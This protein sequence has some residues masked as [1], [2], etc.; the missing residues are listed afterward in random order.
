MQRRSQYSSP[1]FKAISDRNKRPQRYRQT[2]SPPP[3]PHPS[4][5]RNQSHAAKPNHAQRNQAPH[6]R[7]SQTS[8][9]RRELQKIWRSVMGIDRHEWEH[10]A[11]KPGGRMARITRESDDPVPLSP[12]AALN[13]ESSPD[14]TSPGQTSHGQS[15]PGQS[16]PDQVLP[17]IV[18]LQPDMPDAAKSTNATSANPP[19]S[20]RPTRARQ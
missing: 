13:P 10:R 1:S 14:Q 15:S 5:L 17:D 8:E 7:L 2:A 16:S 4:V 12:D 9:P 20:K 6:R 11:Y 18:S 19:S 3:S